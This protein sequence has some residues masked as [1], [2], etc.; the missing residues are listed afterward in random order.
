MWGLGFTMRVPKSG[1]VST[2]TNIVENARRWALGTFAGIVYP[3]LGVFY[4]AW[5]DGP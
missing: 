2:A 3:D 5:C 4:E 1:P